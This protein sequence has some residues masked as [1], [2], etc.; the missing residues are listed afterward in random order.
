[1]KLP[2]VPRRSGTLIPERHAPWKRS[3]GNVAGT[4]TT[5]ENT[6]CAPRIFQNGGALRNSRRRGRPSGTWNLPI[7]SERLADSTVDEERNGR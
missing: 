4:R 5:D 1:M 6:P 3:A 2:C 7:A